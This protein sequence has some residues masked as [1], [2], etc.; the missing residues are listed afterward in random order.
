MLSVRSS[1]P[2]M[3]AVLCSHRCCCV[4]PAAGVPELPVQSLTINCKTGR[5]PDRLQPG[6]DTSQAC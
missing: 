3:C 6:A 2:P 5:I 4:H 1:G